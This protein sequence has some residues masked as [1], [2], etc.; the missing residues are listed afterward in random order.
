MQHIFFILYILS[1]SIGLA[2]LFV[3]FALYL[4]YRRKEI[5]YY[6]FVLFSWM[7]FFVIKVSHVY[8]IVF[9]QGEVTT[10]A[11]LLLWP[12][13]FYGVL[14]IIAYPLLIHSLLGIPLK[15]SRRIVFRVIDILLPI[16]LTLFLIFFKN[17]KVR[18]SSF[19]ILFITLILGYGLILFLI[20][21][22]EL[23]SHFFKKSLEIFFFFQFFLI[24]LGFFTNYFIDQQNQFFSTSMFQVVFLFGVT[25]FHCFNL[26]FSFRYFNTPSYL[27]NG[28][29]TDYFLKSFNLSEREGEII[30]SICQG[31]SNSETAKKLFI[32]QKTVE[33]HLYNIY[34]KTEV[35]NRT[36]LLNLLYSKKSS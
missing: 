1:F 32:S 36:Q 4:Q 6:V 9:F 5:L 27:E 26:Y 35:K 20:H 17:E 11:P 22:K 33:T 16:L 31:A 28:K 23:G 19:M 13:F 10:Y 12:F 34:Q 7:I 30:A 24:F 25:L 8:L 3:V 18:L 14:F 15:G 21:R 29:L 2:S